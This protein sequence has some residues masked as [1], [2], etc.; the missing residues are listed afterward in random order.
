MRSDAIP[1]R[2]TTVG[3]GRVAACSVGGEVG[4][5]AGPRIASTSTICAVRERERE[6]GDDPVPHGRDLRRSRSSGDRAR[7]RPRPAQPERRAP[8]DEP[9]VGD[10][11]HHLRAG[12]RE[13]D[14]SPRA[15]RHAWYALMRLRPRPSANVDAGAR[16][17]RAAEARRRAG[18]QVL[19]RAR[20]RAAGVPSER[21]APGS[22]RARGSCRCRARRRSTS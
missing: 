12:G 8:H 2:A 18:E 3:L 10:A 4:G 15:S 14:A 20:V 22:R 19:R 16:R 5:G 1:G 7:D 6:A 17:G 21:S 11:E 9:R 13:P